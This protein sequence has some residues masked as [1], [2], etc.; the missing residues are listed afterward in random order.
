MDESRL[1]ALISILSSSYR[2]LY[3][4]FLYENGVTFL[5]SL[6]KSH[7]DDDNDSRLMRILSCLDICSKDYEYS[8]SFGNN[9]GHQLIKRLKKKYSSIDSSNDNDSSSDM[10]ELLESIECNII[11]SGCVYPIICLTPITDNNDDDKYL[12]DVFTFN[13][14]D[15]DDKYHVVLKRVPKSMHGHGQKSVGYILWSGAIIL[16]R[17]INYNNDIIKDKT[18][19]EIGAGLGLLGM[20]AAKYAS[21]VAMTDYNEIVLQTLVK[22]VEINSRNNT[23]SEDVDFLGGYKP[24]LTNSDNIDVFYHDWDTLDVEPFTF[25]YVPCS[26]YGNINDSKTV[27]VTTKENADDNYAPLTFPSIDINKMY[28][29]VIASDM[30]CCEN[31]AVGIAKSVKTFLKPDGICLFV[32]PQP[33]FRYGT[34]ALI[35][36]LKG[37]GMKVVARPICNSKYKNDLYEYK[38]SQ[39]DNNDDNNEDN[40]YDDRNITNI[41]NSKIIDDEYLTDNIH[42]NNYIAWNFIIAKW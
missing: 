40:I 29:V 13:Q 19:L 7:I 15:N 17:W 21:H 8:N 3:N 16:S 32:I 36:A 22:N 5:L 34:E 30:I 11:S 27:N 12:P 23:I 10:L 28:D 31:D 24:A 4:F 1:D 26:P 9:G 25:S 39:N 6:L 18:V 38:K 41:I 37:I 33:Q 2:S 14:I 35:P 42:D 20:V